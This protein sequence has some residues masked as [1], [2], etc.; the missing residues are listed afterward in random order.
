[1]RIEGAQRP[2]AASRVTL[3]ENIDA[4]GVKKATLDWR[5]TDEDYD[6]LYQSSIAF[7]RGVGAAG[8][9]RVNLEISKNKDLSKVTGTGHHLGTTRMHND[10][11]QGV[12]DQNCRV[13]DLDNC[14][15]AGSSVFPTGPRVNP[16]LTIVALAIR[17]ADH[18]KTKLNTL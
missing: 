16:T 9:G 11:Q 14:F 2:N 18:L 4:L 17:L 3:N 5:I 13:H 1:M 7:A 10:P 12:V 15:I 6:N 8:F